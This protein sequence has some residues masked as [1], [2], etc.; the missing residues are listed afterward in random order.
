MSE[1]TPEA[2]RNR[3]AVAAIGALL[4]GPLL[5]GAVLGPPVYR[6]LL[7]MQSQGVDFTPYFSIHFRRVVSRIVTVAAVAL[8]YPALKYTGMNSLRQIGFHEGRI[9][10]RRLVLGGWAVGA[11]TMFAAYA[12]AWAIGVYLWHGGK[13]TSLSIGALLLV[14]LASAAV[15][16]TLEEPFFRGF[17]YGVFRRGLPPARAVFWAALVFALVHLPRP[18]NPQGLDGTHWLAGFRLLPHLFSGVKP[19]TLAPAFLTLFVMGVVL[20]LLYERLRSLYGLIGLHAGWVWGIG[21]CGSLLETDPA[22][23]AFAFWPSIL[24]SKTYGGLAMALIFLAAVLWGRRATANG[25]E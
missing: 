15:I 2:I 23:P 19:E 17:I 14:K 6:L 20:C 25:R 11:L 5:V 3:R 4:L 1:R 16:A 24:V 12:A 7:W 18:A 22:H 10:A 13:Y 8:L 21:V 9:P